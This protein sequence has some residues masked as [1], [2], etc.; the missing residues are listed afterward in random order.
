[1]PA[2]YGVTMDGHDA[3]NFMIDCASLKTTSANLARQSN[4]DSETHQTY[5]Q[6]EQ[7]FTGQEQYNTG[8]NLYYDNHTHNDQGMVNM[9][10]NCDVANQNLN[11]QDYNQG[12]AE[13]SYTQVADYNQQQ[14]TNP[15]VTTYDQQHL[16]DLSVTSYVVQQTTGPQVTNYIQ[17]PATDPQVTNYDQQQ[18]I[19]PQDDDYDQYRATN[20]SC[21]LENVDRVNQGTIQYPDQ[22]ANFQQH[23]LYV[24]CPANVTTQNNGEMPS[25]HDQYTTGYQEDAQ[26]HQQQ[27]TQLTSGDEVIAFEQHKVP[28]LSTANDHEENENMQQDTIATNSSS[29]ASR[30]AHQDNP[31][32]NYDR[33]GRVISIQ[34][35]SQTVSLVRMDADGQSKAHIEALKH[36][37]R[38]YQ[39]KLALK[40]HRYQ[41]LKSSTKTQSNKT[42]LLES[43]KSCKT[44][45]S[46]CVFEI[47]KRQIKGSRPTKHG[48]RWSDEVKS[49]SSAIYLRSK[50]AYRF[51]RKSIDLPS[52]DIVKRY[53]SEKSLSKS[54]LYERDDE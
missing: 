34:Y 48:N 32:I 24:P 36:K 22:T 23:D 43:L 44:E 54:P 14:E 52:E 10:P 5:Q 50:C 42:R 3:E 2:P 6:Q 39:R 53:I 29:P 41:K 25:I 21:I 8:T 46:P 17:P 15:Q 20:S 35:S 30:A 4:D 33:E 38:Y 40:T 19:S 9:Y 51:V 31:K 7:Y 28:E 37:I 1:M 49:F 16:T 18:V 11:Y 12:I 13:N 26:Q 45:F 47:I 27:Q